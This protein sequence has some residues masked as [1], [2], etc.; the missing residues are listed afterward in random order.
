MQFLF[1]K[2]F[3]S[4]TPKFLSYHFG[5]VISFGILYL[6]SDFIEDRFSDF[7]IKY[8]NR[9]SSADAAKGL[10]GGGKIVQS[11]VYW[12]WYALVTQSTLGYGGVI[13]AKGNSIPFY[14]N[15]YPFQFLNI[16]QICSIFVIS[17]YS[18]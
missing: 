8:L 15:S 7:S 2:V 4:K 5:A 16:S 13:D 12:L 1:R 18:V 11:L 14:K 9:P 10:A 17:A 6:L 3:K